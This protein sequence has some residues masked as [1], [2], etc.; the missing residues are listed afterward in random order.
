MW[1]H[2]RPR[3]VQGRCIETR[4]DLR[5]H[6]H[7]DEHNEKLAEFAARAEEALQDLDQLNSWLLKL[8]KET[9]ETLAKARAALKRININIYDLALNEKSQ[10][11][12]LVIGNCCL[13]HRAAR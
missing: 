4:G 7:T 9:E 1:H 12:S 8:G 6:F 13:S 10:S 11:K 2:R 3:C 5:E